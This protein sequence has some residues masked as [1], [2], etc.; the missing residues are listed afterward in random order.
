MPDNERNQWNGRQIHNAV[1]TAAALAQFKPEDANR[2]VVKHF[3]KVE[4]ASKEFD[5]YLEET[6][7]QDELAIAH[8]NQ[9]RADPR[10]ADLYK[11]KPANSRLYRSR[12]S[13]DGYDRQSGGIDLASIPNSR[14][15]TSKPSGRQVRKS[16]RS[17]VE[18]DEDDEEEE[19]YTGRRQSRTNGRAAGE[20][21]DEELSDDE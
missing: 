3:K 15:D 20:A 10:K 2:L 11:Q 19:D 13:S 16:K 21:R 17:V 6:R 4:K 8:S 5:N 12:A 1:R 18:D 14:F 7:G 9:D